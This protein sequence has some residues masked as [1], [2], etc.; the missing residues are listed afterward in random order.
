[1]TGANAQKFDVSMN[2]RRFDPR[3][4]FQG[5]NGPPPETNLQG[6]FSRRVPLRRPRGADSPPLP[7]EKMATLTPRRATPSARLH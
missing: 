3:A 6:A 7:L 5:S 4:V 2:R 1:M